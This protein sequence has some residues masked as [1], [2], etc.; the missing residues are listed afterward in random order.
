MTETEARVFPVLLSGGSGTRLWPLSRSLYPKQLLPLSG[1]ETMLQATALRMPADTAFAPPLVICNNDHRFI[2][3]E[4]LRAIGRD[5][6]SIMLEP[7][8]RNTAPAA[9]AAA[10]FCRRQRE[11]AVIVLLPADH[12]IRDVP[13][14]RRRLDQAIAL[15]DK[16]HIVTFGIQ[17][18]EPHTG[19]GYILQGAE[20]EPEAFH[21]DQFTEKPDAATATGYIAAGGYSWNSGMFVARAGVLLDE[22]A[23]FRP[24]IVESVTAALDRAEPD[25]DFLRLDEE[26]FAACPAQSIDFAVMERTDR[27]AVI[28]CAFGWSDIGSWNALWEIADKD[29]DG[30]ATAGDVI[31]KDVKNSYIHTEKTVVA[32]IGVSDLTVVETSDAVLIAHRDRAQDVKD[33]VEV[34]KSSGRQEHESHVRHYR[35]WGYYEPLDG[36]PRFQV[37]RLMVKPGAKL[38]FQLHHHR[39]EH[40]VVVTGTAEVTNGN[41]TR[42]LS[43]NESTFIPI[44]TPHRLA[45]PGKVDLEVIEIQSGTYLGEDDIVRLDDPYNRADHETK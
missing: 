32:A 12:V 43:E 24:D 40:W 13:E 33:V 7:V 10:L 22:M 9:A 41:E 30:N 5:A 1:E 34:L 39:A 35:P 37:K 8:G 15:A 6:L 16:G 23:A 14:F 44:G 25:L 26:A 11:D 17:P 18:T 29:A 2:I 20:I 31:L 28:P 38:S 36:G 4:Q 27:A 19:Y 45:N 3:A 21:I 42:L